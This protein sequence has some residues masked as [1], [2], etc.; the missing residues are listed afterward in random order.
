L[1][2]GSAAP[3]G[4]RTAVPHLSGARRALAPIDR[5]SVVAFALPFF[6]Y[7]LTV[8]PTIYNLDSAELSTAAATGGVVRATG[9]PVYLLI[10]RLWSQL[11]IGDVGYR[12]NLLSAFSGALTLVLADRILRRLNVGQWAALGALGLLA[13]APFFWAMSLVAE[14]Y[15]LHTALMAAIILLLLRWGEEPTALRLALVGLV[16]GL[17]AG[18]HV[19]TVLL[20]PG[21]AWYVLTVAPRKTLAP[22]SLLAAVAGLALGLSVYAYLP[23]RFSYAPS[24][25]YAGQFGADGV[26]RPVN[27]KTWAG[28]WWLV[29]GRSFAGEM[30]AYSGAE[31]WSEAASFGTQL[32]RSFFAIGVGP[33]LLGIGVLLRRDWRLGGMYLLMFGVSA[34]FYIDYAV[35][36]KDTMFLPAYLIWALWLAVGAQWLLDWLRREDNPLIQNWGVLVLRISLIAIVLLAIVWNWQ[37][38]DVSND[39]SA[40]QQGEEILD[41]AQPH[42][43]ILGWWDTVPVIEYLQQVEGQRLDVKAINRFLISPE[44][45]QVLIQRQA[46]VRP[47]YIDD[48]PAELLIHFRA[49]PAGSIYQL[50]PR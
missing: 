28:L 7:L 41:V 25:N 9:Y 37:V 10:G 45:M 4:R 13:T 26:F 20:V 44:D 43:L 16:V 36:D 30:L 1:N 6:L 14:V 38:A 47:I 29:S 49:K 40:R 11:P 35:V 19:A 34:G 31:L 33:G 50:S 39:W 15:T 5:R 27:L 32:W 8:A 12:M 2:I 21:C 22:R 24:F 23:I 3:E 42:A 18:N 17:S 48:P 46:A